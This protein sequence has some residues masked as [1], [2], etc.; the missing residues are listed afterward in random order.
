MR[1]HRPK[2]VRGWESAGHHQDSISGCVS[3]LLGQAPTQIVCG[4]N[5]PSL[6][7]QGQ[8][9]THATAIGQYSPD[10]ADIRSSTVQSHRWT[11]VCNTAYIVA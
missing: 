2:N 9:M 1:S 11:I 3:R 5:Y 7:A 10:R 4:V 8:G 6:L